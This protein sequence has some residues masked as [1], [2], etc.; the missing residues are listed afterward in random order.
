[1]NIPNSINKKVLWHY[2]NLKIHRK[3]HH[4]HVFSVL[5]ILFDEIVKDLLDGKEIKIVN[6][7][8]LVLKEMKPR[9]YHDVRYNC[10]MQSKGHKILRFSL[11]PKIRKKMCYFLDIDKTFGDD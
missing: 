6:F 5:S 2:V 4:G 11:S 3:I 1:M 7:G 10:V 9:K 8:T